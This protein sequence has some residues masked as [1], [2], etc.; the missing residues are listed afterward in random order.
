MQRATEAMAVTILANLD[1]REWGGRKKNKTM[2]LAIR[3]TMNRF[4][5]PDDS[6]LPCL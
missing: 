3:S 4:L 5:C 1:K 6:P 2:A